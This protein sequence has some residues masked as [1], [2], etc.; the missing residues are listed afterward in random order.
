MSNPT[1]FAALHEPVA[2]LFQG[3]SSPPDANRSTLHLYHAANSICSQKVRTVLA[4]TKRPYESHIINI[5]E[6]QNYHPD[7]V[8][9]RMAGCASTGLPL[10]TK[11]LG[12]TSALNGGCD[13]CV[14]PTL[15]DADAEKIIVDSH[16][17]CR[18]LDR[19]NTTAPSALVPPRFRAQIE[20]ELG[21]IDNLPNY[22]ILAM[23]VGS[24]SG[25]IPNGF[26]LSKVSRCDTL[27]AEHADDSMLC[28]AY[29]AKRSKEKMAAERLFDKESLL[30]AYAG[31]AE[32]VGQ[33]E[34]R[35]PPNSNYLFGDAATMADL[36]WGVELLRF[37]DLGLAVLWE[38]GRL[39]RVASYFK[40]L[41]S[42]PS[43][44]YSVTDWPNARLPRRADVDLE[45]LGL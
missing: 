23:G 5:F 6:G 28:A 13:A 35:L 10:A 45:T 19:S 1:A 4:H 40:V 44:A 11:H 33:L 7:Y 12:S 27:L 17:I 31:M 22:Q 30:N 43:I 32:A 42:L 16:H 36:F 8:R 24:T 15:V 38:N 34:L 3:A 2:R 25:E 37:E 14:V 9:M 20:A 26:A 41:C 21:I 39:P 18:E 29:G